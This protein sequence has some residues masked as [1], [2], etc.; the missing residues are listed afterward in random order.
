MQ[1]KLVVGIDWGEGEDKTAQAL[2]VYKN[3]GINEIPV[4]EFRTFYDEEAE[5]LY[6]KLVGKE[7]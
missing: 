1:E 7:E 5:A 4:Y 2:T 6:K 3:I